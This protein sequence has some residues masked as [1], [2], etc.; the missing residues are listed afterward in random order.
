MTNLLPA[1]SKTAAVFNIMKATLGAGALSLPFTMLSAGVTLGLVLLVV[2][3]ALSILSLGLIVRAVHKSGKDTYEELVDLLF[4]RRW[5]YLYQLAMFVFCFGTS[6]VY[7]VTIYDIVR[8]VT[9]HAF[10]ENPEEWYAVLLTNRLYFSILVTVV[11]LLPVSLMKTIDSI[12]YL[13]FTGSLCACFL[14]ITSVYVLARY[15]VASE[16]HLRYAVEAHGSVVVVEG[17]LFLV[18][19]GALTESNILTSLGPRLNSGDPV[20]AAAFLMMAVAIVGTFPL[21]IYPV[22]TTVLHSLRPK[23]YRTLIGM[24][25]S[26]VTVGLAFAVALALPDVNVILGLV[27]ALAGSIICFLGP[28]AFNIKLDGGAVYI[29]DRIYYWAMIIIGLVAFLLGTYIAILDAIEFYQ[30]RG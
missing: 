7:I 9:V 17:S 3:A 10:G 26:T 27:G 5:C 2:M 11:V 29:R 13:T 16:L 24:V 14:A 19:Y 1:G 23:K 28:A 21:N 22:R 18:A 25:V 4:G 20:I 8:P 30:E 15:G 6:A 12:R